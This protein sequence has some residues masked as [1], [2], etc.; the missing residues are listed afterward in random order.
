MLS[1]RNERAG[2]EATKFLSYLLV[3]A[4]LRLILW[5]LLALFCLRVIGQMLVAFWGVA[6]LSPMEAWYSGLLP[7]SLLLPAQFIII[8]LYGKVCLDFTRQQGFFYSPRRKLGQGLLIFGLV[9]LA[10]M[11]FR[12]IIWLSFYPG[13]W[14][15]GGSIPIFFH[16]VLAGFILLVGSYHWLNPGPS[17]YQNTSA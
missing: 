8:L 9:Y 6:W 16:W 3:P 10:V 13:P 1:S 12:F 4:R 2:G 11:G 7:Y 17:E 14:W 15:M 5:F